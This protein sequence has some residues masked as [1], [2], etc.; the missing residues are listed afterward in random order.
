MDIYASRKNFATTDV[1]SEGN[2]DNDPADVSPVRNASKIPLSRLQYL[3]RKIH[4][5]GPRPLYE[6]LCELADGAELAS[7]LERY[8]RL[9]PLAGFVAG[10]GGDQLPPPAR[11]VGGRR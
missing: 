7:A 1:A 5:L 11:I 3:A 8:A 10:L 4:G 2:F 9:G 6:L